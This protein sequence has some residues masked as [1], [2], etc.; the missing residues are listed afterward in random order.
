MKDTEQFMHGRVRETGWGHW[1]M[2][3]HVG[4]T[5]L[6]MCKVFPTQSVEADMTVTSI[7]D[8]TDVLLMYIGGRDKRKHAR[9]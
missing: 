4:T 9:D 1:Q 5:L 7:D 8:V 3:R 6:H 2:H